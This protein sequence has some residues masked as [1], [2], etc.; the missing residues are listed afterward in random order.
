MSRV[1]EGFVTSSLYETPP[2]YREDQPKFLNCVFG[3][4]ATGRRVAAGPYK[5]LELIREIERETGRDREKSGPMGPRPIDIDILLYGERVVH[6][7]ELVIPHPRMKER[8]FVLIP[9]VE[10][11]PD[12]RD[13]VTGELYANL[14]RGLGREGIYHYTG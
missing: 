10:L 9:L 8:P 4:N 12:L 5:L 11:A 7:D 2:M 14:A 3:G 6:A 1:L 13:P